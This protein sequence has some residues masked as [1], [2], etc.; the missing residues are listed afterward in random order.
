MPA[1]E[2][3]QHPL[4][5]DLDACA[6]GCAGNHA[7]KCHVCEPETIETAAARFPATF[8]LRGFPGKTFRI[9]KESSFMRDATAVLYTQIQTPSGWYD[10]AK[11]TADEL[12]REV[13]L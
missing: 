2:N 10:F 4:F 6:Y 12:S 13:V 11:G 7:D 8:G 1:N 3:K 9:S 5:D